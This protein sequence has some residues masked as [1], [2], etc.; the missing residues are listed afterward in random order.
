MSDAALAP[1]A[2]AEKGTSLWQDAL[3]RLRRNRLALFGL[4]FIVVA[5]AIAIIT[6][7]I[8]PYSYEAQDLELGPAPPDAAHWLGTDYL[9]RDLLTRLLYGGRI[10]LMVGFAAT[11]VSLLIG[12]LY[13]ATAGFVGGRT[14]ALMMRLVDILYALPFTIFVIILM[15]FFGHNIILLFMAIGAVEWLTM[16]RIVR[17]SVIS[18]RKKEFIEAAEAMGFSQWRILTRHVIPNV[19]GPI[20][21]YTTLTIPQVMLLEAFLSFLGLGVQAPMS[22]WGLLIRDGADHMEQYPWLLLF[23]SI[24][25]SVTL[26]S[27]NFLGDGLRDA[28]DPKASRD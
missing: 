1:V 6:P 21:V 16:A 19:L 8:A 24:T 22:S 5:S 27:L 3:R 13:G 12:V 28:L 20:I 4:C 25:L 10:S 18:L 2:Q 17:G 15:V 14:D 23:P 9:G 7:L 11:S 26:F